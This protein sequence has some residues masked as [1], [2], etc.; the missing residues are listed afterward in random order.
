MIDVVL[1][2]TIVGVVVVSFAV[3]AAVLITFLRY[4]TR[5]GR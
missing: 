2:F 1:M 4:L 5:R 3:D